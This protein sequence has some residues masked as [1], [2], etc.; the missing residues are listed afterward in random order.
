LSHFGHCKLE[1]ETY[2]ENNLYHLWIVFAYL[3]D[4][5]YCRHSWSTV[6]LQSM[7]KTRHCPRWPNGQPLL[8][9]VLI[10]LWS[11]AGCQHTVLLKFY[12]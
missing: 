3:Y 12:V 2:F 8:T 11:F 1:L 10:L 5:P 6:I 4:C 9:Q 7:Y